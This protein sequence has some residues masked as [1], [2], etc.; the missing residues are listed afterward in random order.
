[1]TVQKEK[2]VACTWQD[3]KAITV[4]FTN[5]R[6]ASTGTVLRRQR[7]GSRKQLP[8]PQAIINY[9]IFMGGVDKGDQSRGYY[10]LKTKTRKFY[11]YI[12]FSL[13][14]CGVAISNAYLLHKHHAPTIIFKHVNCRLSISFNYIASPLLCQS[15]SYCTSKSKFS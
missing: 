7:G 8:C 11:K 4:V 10:M 12:F 14:I 3:N 13:S 2:I 5:C 15:P 9:K 1:M 6:P